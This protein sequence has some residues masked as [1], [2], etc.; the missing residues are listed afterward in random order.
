MRI[1]IQFRLDGQRQILPLNYQYP[2]SAWIYKVLGTADWEFSKFLH[3]L[4][5]QLENHKTFKLFTFSNLQFPA[6]SFRVLKGTDRMEIKAREASLIIAFMLPNAMQN[7]VAGLFSSQ[8][9]EIADRISGIQMQVANVVMFPEPPPDSKMRIRVISPIVITRKT[10]SNIQEQYIAPG[11]ADYQMLFFKNLIDKH[12]AWQR[13]TNQ[14]LT[15]FIDDELQFRCLTEKPKSR[16]QTIKAFTRDEVKVRGYLFDFEITALPELIFTGLDAG[17][18]AM[19]ALG[20]GCGEV[21]TTNENDN[22]SN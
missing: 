22:I 14:A 19:N 21:I 4:G 3:E 9:C 13:Q 7:F 15:D 2:L 11:D 8:Q 1:R 10:E 16:L 20:F 12:H 18:G 17:F 6:G 5:Y